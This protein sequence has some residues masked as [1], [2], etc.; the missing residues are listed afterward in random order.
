[1]AKKIIGLIIILIIIFLFFIF[2]SLDSLV[3]KGITHYGSKALGVPVTVGHLS[4]STLSGKGSI[5]DFEIANP[6]GYK[7]PYVMKV[8]KLSFSVKPKTLFSDHIVINSIKIEGLDVNYEVGPKGNNIDQL[9]KNV[10]S[11][12]DSDDADAKATPKVKPKAGAKA[13]SQKT[14]TLYLFSVT[15]SSVT[16][17]LGVAKKTIKLPDIVLKDLGTD[18]PLPVAQLVQILLNKL[19]SVIS[20]QGVSG[21][22][23]SFLGGS[24]GSG[25]AAAG[26]GLGGLVPDKLQGAVKNLGGKLKG[27]LN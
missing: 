5:E 2:F 24:S 17:D 27:L 13:K 20:K 9:R 25:G 12:V 11:I 1:M 18:K 10:K 3:K 23:Q 8:G 21:L 6:K 15:N 14:V 26:G 22:A 7:S 4:L 16:G 19:T